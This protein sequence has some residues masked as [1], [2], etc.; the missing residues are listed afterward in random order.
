MSHPDRSRRRS[1]ED[2]V[3]A[4]AG[5][6]V[7]DRR[8]LAAFRRVRRELFVPQDRVGAA[9]DDRPVPIAHAQVTTQPSLVG[10]MVAA[11][12]L[13]GGERVLEVGTGL[14]FQAAV[15]GALVP[16]GRVWTV[17][18]FADLAE[19]ASANLTAAGIANVTVVVADGTLGWP[20]AAPYDAVVV[21]AAAPRVPAPLAAQLAEGG[22]LVQPLGPGGDELVTLLR[23]R[24]GRLVEQGMVVPAHFVRLVGAHGLP[25]PRG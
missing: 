6:G 4:V 25:E 19:R 9:Y 12:R 22:R 13:R 14:G 24:G 20:P 1:P 3:R 23:K 21:A 8:V 10:R 16:R 5:A 2:L 15:L 17:E 11:L 7:D 18:R